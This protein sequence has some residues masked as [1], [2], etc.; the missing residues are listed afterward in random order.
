M[1]RDFAA[2]FWISLPGPYSLP[3]PVRRRS[4]SRERLRLRLQEIG[5]KRKVGTSI[6]RL[7]SGQEGRGK[8]LTYWLGGPIQARGRQSWRVR[9]L[10][11][12]GRFSSAWAVVEKTAREKREKRRK[13]F[14]GRDDWIDTFRK[15]LYL[16]LN[17]YVETR[18]LLPD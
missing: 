1:G 15:K 16:H 2:A 11:R 4:S 17:K 9:N 5:N 6:D 13:S 7:A 14:E 18:A 12:T 10:T 8:T 3:C